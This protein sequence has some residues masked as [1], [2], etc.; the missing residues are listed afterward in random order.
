MNFKRIACRWRERSKLHKWDF[1][2]LHTH[3]FNIHNVIWLILVE[4]SCSLCR[5][6]I[7]KSLKR[8]PGLFRV[9]W[10]SKKINLYWKLNPVWCFV[11][12]YTVQI[13]N[14]TPF[15]IET[16]E[17][18]SL[19]KIW[20]KKN[21]IRIPQNCNFSFL[22]LDAWMWLCVIVLSINIHKFLNRF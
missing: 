5:N 17:L 6:Y 12:L 2:V 7:S 1:H 21:W 8:C 3:F 9:N 4:K 16:K 14:Q 20:R 10:V 13:E 19:N 11:L 15:V 18:I 22:C